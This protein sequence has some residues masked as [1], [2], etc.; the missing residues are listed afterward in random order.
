MNPRCLC[1]F[2]AITWCL[3]SLGGCDSP[4]SVVDLPPQVMT[5]TIEL[6]PLTL[7]RELTGRVR[8]PRTAQVRAQASGIVLRQ[9]F[10]EGSE[11]QRG[12][13][14][15]LIDPAPLQVERDSAAA[16]LRKARA[17]LAQARVQ[18]RRYEQLA[19]INAISQQEFD[20]A[21]FA[22]QQLAAEVDSTQAALHRAQL[23]L[24]YATVRA[25]ISGRAGRALVTE[26]A[27]V[28]QDE[29]TLMVNI[30]Q[31]DPVYVDLTQS[32]REFALL[33]RALRAG[34]LQ[35]AGQEQARL[36]LLEESG[37]VYPLPGRLLFSDLNVEESTGQI[38]LRS[39]FPN[40]DGDL[41]PG[42]F[43]RVRL[44]Q[45]IDQRAITVARRAV[46]LDAGGRAW[47][48]LVAADGTVSSR[49]I[50]TDGTEQDR[51]IVS[52]GLNA[53]ERV[54]TD[55]LQHVRDGQRVQI[56]DDSH[57]AAVPAH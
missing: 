35:D 19:R 30:Q 44:A 15:F 41:L 21:H 49:S 45:G 57:V 29:A 3:V 50:R 11:V 9:V 36:Q 47:V 26:G 46:A 6:K 28:G 20:G 25:P 7:T 33:R 42:S 23:N 43:V 52:D 54:I 39:E 31:L 5:E 27:L 17:S 22:E 40:P 2:G 55:G 34:S 4:P 24:Q 51:W 38:V 32:T 1:L 13:V 48:R 53:G 37:A 18:V 8:A 12:E 56:M 14:L 10:K 16:N